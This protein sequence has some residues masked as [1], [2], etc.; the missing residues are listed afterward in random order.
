M[1]LGY[2]STTMGIDMKGTGL[3]IKKKTWKGC[4]TIQGMRFSIK[5]YSTTTKNT[6]IGNLNWWTKLIIGN[7]SNTLMTRPFFDNT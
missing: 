1:V 7:L 6:T 5:A 4:C 2:S 3:K